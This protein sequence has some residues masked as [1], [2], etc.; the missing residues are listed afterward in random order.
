MS[1]N[2]C[3]DKCVLDPCPMCKECGL[4][5]TVT[6]DDLICEDIDTVVA[7]YTKPTFRT[8]SAINAEW[9]EAASEA[10]KG[11]MNLTPSE[12]LRVITDLA[13]LGNNLILEASLTAQ[14]EAY[15]QSEKQR[16]A[17][18]GR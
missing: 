11:S 4:Q 7:E 9:S 15:Q 1:H 5:V 10:I 6:D 2:I 3:D 16:E 17:R 14:F 13:L 12:T 18:M 8:F